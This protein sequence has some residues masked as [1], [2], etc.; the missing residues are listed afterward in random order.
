MVHGTTESQR[1][2]DQVSCETELNIRYSGF[3][4]VRETW[5]RPLEISWIDMSD[6]VEKNSLVLG[7]GKL[8]QPLMTGILISWVPINPYEIGL[9]TRPSPF[10]WKY[11]MGVDRPDRT[12]IG[13]Y[14]P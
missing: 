12:H 5:V 7:D 6:R 1:T 11:I 10:T 9:M 2:P 3:F 14:G 4:G 8:I 13:C